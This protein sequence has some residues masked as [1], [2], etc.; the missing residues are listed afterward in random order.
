ME[1]HVKRRKDRRKTMKWER[2][3]VEGRREMKKNER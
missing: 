3:K 2:K 1:V